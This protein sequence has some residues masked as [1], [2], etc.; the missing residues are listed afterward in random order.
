MT[1]V[2]DDT[3][4]GNGG[5]CSAAYTCCGPGDRA[6]KTYRVGMSSLRFSFYACF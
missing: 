3:T 2:L 5:V 4:C 1:Q 6:C